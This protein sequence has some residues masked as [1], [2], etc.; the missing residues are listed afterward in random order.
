M[1]GIVLEGLSKRYPGGIVACDRL[2]LEVYHGELLA[3]LGPS[4]SGKSTLLRLVA[5]L[6][7]PTDG[8]IHIGTRPVNGVAARHRDVAMVFQSHALY[9]HWTVYK[10]L[11]F[12]LRSFSRKEIDDRVLQTAAKLGIES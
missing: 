8:A 10:N 5:G 2:D 12:G 4:G 1:A 6:E 7:R 9:P 11:S 3:L